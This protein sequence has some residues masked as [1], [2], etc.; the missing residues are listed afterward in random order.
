[1]A[2]GVREQRLVAAALQ[3][4]NVPPS[5]TSTQPA[6]SSSARRDLVVGD[7]ARAH[8]RPDHRV[9]ALA[10]GGEQRVQVTSRERD[11]HGRDATPASRRTRCGG[12]LPDRLHA[13]PPM[14]PRARRCVLGSCSP[15]CSSPPR[16]PPRTPAAPEDVLHTAEGYA[17]GMRVSASYAAD[18]GAR[19][20]GAETSRHDGAGRRPR[21][22]WP[23][24]LA[25]RRSALHDRRA[26]GRALDRGAAGDDATRPGSVR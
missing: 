9:P 20:G 16:S 17:I 23:S 24:G 6:G 12:E 7:R 15:R 2:D 25:I 19:A 13:R 26:G 10:Q 14:P 5:C 1:M 3:A 11:G 18:P 8:A 4:G 21:G 22:R